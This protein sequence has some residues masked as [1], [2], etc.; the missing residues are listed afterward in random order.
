LVA[1]GK[2]INHSRMT[3]IDIPVRNP[4]VVA[5]ENFRF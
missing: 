3:S 2:P 1:P 4:E 5:L